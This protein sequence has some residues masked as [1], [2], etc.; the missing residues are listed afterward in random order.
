MK[1]C[2]FNKYDKNTLLQK[3]IHEPFKRKTISFYR[4][5]KINNPQEY[6]DSLYL[7]LD[8]MGVLG[9]IYIAHE[10]IN[11]Q[12]N[13][14]EPKVAD[15]ISYLDT[16][17]ELKNMPLKWALEE[18]QISF[19]KLKIKVRKKIVA[20]GLNDDAYDFTNVGKHLTAHEFN[21]AMEDPN[22]VVVDM[23]NHYESEIGH[24]KGAILPDVESFREEL[25]LVKDLLEDKKDKKILLYCTGGVRCEKASA[26]L[27]HYG[28]KDVNQLYGGIIEYAQQVKKNGL[29]NKFIGKNFVFDD[30]LGERISEEIIATCHQCG[31]TCDTHV[32]CANV[33]CNLLFIQCEE[34]AKNFSGCCTPKCQQIASLP[35]EEQVKLR[36]GKEA[37]KRFFKGVKNPTLLRNEIEKQLKEIV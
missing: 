10:G 16:S 4:Y 3:V 5:V 9:R 31:K 12:I 19:L 25:P 36:K 27:K 20:D 29:E 30:R 23:R 8:K 21:Q 1:P 35:E 15:F 18:H 26:Y 6:R 22:S 14:P 33:A 34:C 13:V 32:N 37:K 7:A 17:D 28:F 2:A 24:F 11:A